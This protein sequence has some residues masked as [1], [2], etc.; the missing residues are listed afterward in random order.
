MCRLFKKMSV[1]L[2]WAGT[3]LGAVGGLS[4]S[5]R[6]LFLSLSLTHTLSLYHSLSHTLSL[7]LFTSHALVL[8][9]SLPHALLSLSLSLF[10]SH[11]PG[12]CQATC[13]CLCRSQ[14]LP[15]SQSRPDNPKL[16]V[17]SLLLSSQELSDIKSLCAFNTSGPRPPTSPHSIHV[18][19]WHQSIIA[20]YEDI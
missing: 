17:S 1:R 20:R 2:G 6:G 5:L 7:S 13:R 11:A 16:L 14:T 15:T 10:L 3:H 9:L 8:S 19:S 4:L 18:S 12:C